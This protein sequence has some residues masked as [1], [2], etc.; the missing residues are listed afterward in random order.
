[1]PESAKHSSDYPALGRR[2][3]FLAIYSAS[4]YLLAGLV[5]GAWKPTGGGEWLWWMSGVSLYTVSTLSAPFFTRPRDSL[6]NALISAPM[7]FTVDL[8]QTQVLRPALEAF[9]WVTFWLVASTAALA[10]VAIA[11]QQVPKSDLSWRGRLSRLS[12]QIV[13]PL[14]NQAVMFTPPALISIVGFY[15]DDPASML[16]LAGAWVCVVTVKPIETLSQIW[17]VFRRQHGQNTASALVGHVRRVDDPN[18]IRVSLL[19]SGSWKADR[20]HTARLAGDRYVDVVPLFV[21]T[22]DDQLIGTGLCRDGDPQSAIALTEVWTSPD[23]RSCDEI[24]MHLAG[25]GRAADLIGFVVEESNIAGIRFEVASGSF[26]SE[27]TLVFVRDREATVYYQVL[28]AVTKEEVFTQNPRGTVVVSAGQ[29][30]TLSTEQA[31]CKHGWVPSMNA[32]VF[33]P[34]GEV[35]AAA[36]VTVKAGEFVLGKVPQSGLL[37]KADLSD[38]VRFHTAIL[39][40]TGTGKTEVVF[41][42]IRAHRAAGRKIVCV[43]FTGEYGPRLADCEPITLG[44]DATALASLDEVVNATEYGKFGAPEEKQALA[45]WVDAN[46]NSV[47]DQVEAFM[48]NPATAIGIFDLPD[49]ANTRAT[50]R[51]TEMYLS[52]VFARARRNRGAQEIVVVLEEAHTIV[53]E[54]NLYRYDKA[55]TDAVV[56]RMAQIALQGRKYGVGL[57]L[58]SQRTALVSKTLLSQCNTCISFAMYDKTGLDYLES[59]FASTHARA[60]PNLRFLQGI[61]FGKAIKSDRPVIFEV[62]FNAQKVKDSE[63]MNVTLRA[64]LAAASAGGPPEAALAEAAVSRIVEEN[65]IVEEDDIPF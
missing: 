54:T 12:Y 16:W 44:F 47:A 14:G 28:D 61:A 6:A 17:D 7:L 39:G 32:P 30:G 9:R 8:S 40:V 15:Q 42:L 35:G 4:L 48:T 58:V 51:A 19:T 3:L 49:I 22:Q 64:T 27:G 11:F 60:I 20:L 10:A 38:M 56:G 23:E 13:V 55:D 41:D 21:Q 59:V 2:L 31:F 5:A 36:D 18:I 65:D 63:A 45:K 52:A 53:P 43:D 57:L 29:L 1:M 37:V 24:V 26:I 25:S 34:K 50:L 46:R 62:A 33:V